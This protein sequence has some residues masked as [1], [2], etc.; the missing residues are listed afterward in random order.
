M[1][2]MT[3]IKA[4]SS[5]A[6]ISAVL[7]ERQAWDAA[8][9]DFREKQD[10]RDAIEPGAAG[11]EEA[12]ELCYVAQEHLILQVPSPRAD[13]LAIKIEM[14]LER[15]DPFDDTIFDDHAEAIAADFYRLTGINPLRSTAEAW[16]DRWKAA[17]GDFGIAYNADGSFR[18]LLRGMIEPDLWK[19][20]DPDNP[21]L[22]PHERLTEE[23]HQRGAVKVL[24]ALL[25]LVPGL[26]D[27]VYEI[28]DHKLLAFLPGRGA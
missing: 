14:A 28:V 6:T 13:E 24:E 10:A 3:S 18:S 9:A 15:A 12:S 21:A 16:I 22:A 25:T 8:L 27:A 4:A 19:P 23:E 2:M 5:H 7:C 11:D 17:G 20:T 26:R 1:N